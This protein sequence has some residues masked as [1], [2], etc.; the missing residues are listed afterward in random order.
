M[1]LAGYG[2]G[3]LGVL[4]AWALLPNVGRR[5]LYLFGLVYLFACLLAVGI[6]GSVGLPANNTSIAWAIGSIL[7]LYTL[8]YD[9]TIGPVC[10]SLVSELPSVRLRSKT[11]V[12]ARAS[13]N[14]LA[15][16]S[17]VI[18][19]YMLNPSAWNWGAKAG[20]F[21]AGACMLSLV[22]TFFCVP[23]PKDRTYAEL[24]ILFQKRVGARR[25]ADTQVS[26]YDMESD[27]GE[28]RRAFA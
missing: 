18:T 26:L 1:T 15:I 22:F 28:E 27:D 16:V 2:L 7:L 9:I 3:I 13:Y 11:I 17:N 5:R 21:W 20:Y 6:L 24:N 19:P 23:E 4:I 10:Y 25:F 14:V 12:L 8:G